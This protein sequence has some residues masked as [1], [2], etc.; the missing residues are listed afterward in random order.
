[1][2]N[3]FTLVE[4]LV[5]ISL[6]SIVIVFLSKTVISLQNSNKSFKQAIHNDSHNIKVLTLLK[7]DIIM[8]DRQTN[9]MLNNENNNKSQ[10]SF[11]TN[12]SIY[13]ISKPFV[14]WKVLKDSNQL[15]RIE[16]TKVDIYKE[17]NNYKIDGVKDNCTIFQIYKE[18]EGKH[19]FIYIKD[20]KGVEVI[21]AI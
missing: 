20:D 1:M 3:G 13:N 14:I 11:Y 10:I 21:T 9:V 19:F 5:S 12:S 6:L 7:R 8:R 2:K 4:I 18:K 16:S 17:S 15:I